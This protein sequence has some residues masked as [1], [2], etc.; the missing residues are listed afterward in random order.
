MRE[1][2]DTQATTPK[3][4]SPRRRLLKWCLWVL[5]SPVLLFLLL[6][7]LVY[8]PPVQDWAVG[9]ATE[10]LSE[11]T[12]KKVSVE[13]L[14]VTPLL[15]VELCN[16][17]ILNPERLTDHDLQLQFCGQGNR[18]HSDTVV[19]AQSCIV[20]LDMM[21][22]LSGRIAVDAFDLRGAR[23]DTQDMLDGLVLDGRLGRFRF[24]V[25]DIE[26]KA[27]Q[28]NLCHAVVDDCR[29]D[30]ALRDTI[31]VE[32]DTTTTEIPWQLY[33]KDIEVNR[34]NIAFHSLRDTMAVRAEMEALELKRGQFDLWRQVLHVED[35][36]ANLP[37]VSYDVNYVVAE[38]SEDPGMSGMSGISGESGIS[39]KSGISGESGHPATAI[40]FNHLLLTGICLDLP[41][42]DYDLNSGRLLARLDELKGRERSGL[43]LSH[44]AAEVEL[45]TS[46]VCVRGAELQTPHSQ[47]RAEVDMDWSA[48]TPHR[49]GRMDATLSAELGKEDVMLLAGQQLP[50]ALLAAYPDKILTAEAELTGN[51]D[52]VN[53]RRFRVIMPEIMDVTA[54][55]SA[56]HLLEEG[57]LAADLT[58]EAETWDMSL[59]E[60]LLGLEGIH[61]PALQFT[62]DTHV[63]D[64]NYAVQGELL[65]GGGRLSL[66]GHYNTNLDSYEADLDARRLK[67]NNFVK[68]DSVLQVTANAY[69]KGR[70]TDLLSPR[71]A[72]RAVADVQ[73]MNYGNRDVSRVHLDALTQNG[74][75]FV[76]F[77]SANEVLD[78]D[79]CVELQVAGRKIADA[80]F[81]VDMRGIDLYSLG[82]TE[83]PLSVSM[84]LHANGHT[85]LKE[86]HYLEGGVSSMQLQTA[87]STY[88]PK[89]ITTKLLMQP[90]TLF[91][92]LS[93]GDL[94]LNLNSRQGL[95]QVIGCVQDYWEELSQ[96]MRQKDFSRDRLI[97]RLPDVDLCVESGRQN[98][99]ANISAMMGYSYKEF[100]IDIHTD[101]VSGINGHGWIHA[102]NTGSIVLDTIQFDVIQNERGM[103]LDS[104]VCNGRRN[105]DISFDARLKATLSPQSASFGLVYLDDRGRKGVD[106]GAEATFHGGTTRIHLNPLR[107]ILA[108]RYFTLNDSNF[109]AIDSLGHVEA[110]LDLQADDGTGLK[111][112]SMPNEMADQDLTLSLNRFNLGELCSVLPYMPMITG[113]LQGDVHLQKM[114]KVLSVGA[115]LLVKDMAYEGSPM[116]D[117]GINA[118]YMPNE[119]GSHY[120]DGFLSQYGLEIMAFSGMYRDEGETDQ[121][122]ADVDLQRFPL[123]MANGFLGDM[124]Q[125]SGYFNGGVHVGGSSAKPSIEGRLLTESMHLL[126]PSY[127]IDLRVPDDT[128]AVVQNRLDL[129]R[130]MAYSTGQRPLQLGGYVDF[131]DFSNIR[132]DVSASARNFELV[133]APRNRKAELYG[134]VFVDLSLLARGHVSDLNVTGNLVVLGNTDLTYVLKDSPITVEDEMADLVTFV[135]FGDTIEVE[136][137]EVVPPSNLNMRIGV[138][139]DQAAQVHCLLSEDGVNYANLEGGGDLTLTYDERRGLQLFGRYT[140]LQ[141]RMNYTLMVMSLK[142]CDIASGSYVDFNGDIM[143]PRLSIAASERLNTTITENETP[144]SVAFNVGMNVTQTLNDMGLEFTL[145]APEDMNIQNELAQMTAEQRGR[146]AVTLMATGMYVVEGKATGGFNT[147]NALNSFL[148][149]QISQITGKALNS[150]DLSLGVQNTNTA[151]GSITTDYSFRFAKR[152]WGNRISLI[153]G[154]KVS[155]GS[156]AENTGQ[157]I[158]DNVSIE[159]RLD[160]SA[161]RYVTLYY[162]NNYESILE[163]QV[164][165]MGAGLVLRRKTSR[166]GELFLFRNKE[167]TVPGDDKSKRKKGG[168][169]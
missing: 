64:G 157:S 46:K 9:V 86:N 82:V 7:I 144:R 15:D 32:E 53:L 159:Y 142:D 165:E 95:G 90:D 100:D 3:R 41:S 58:W 55:G 137:D 30:I 1:Q 40:D 98:P 123:S 19:C 85:D 104:R 29:L 8:L 130:L 110:D 156:E 105:P 4:R 151:S 145:E 44:L 139:I 12:G 109:V 120:V 69:L 97:A 28:V 38:P 66:D 103:L 154:G 150:V 158:I 67:V 25:H 22:L 149:S 128:I 161:T 131:G 118:A 169:K 52:S 60:R 51:I 166:L 80:S 102:V 23:V 56:G 18:V 163:G 34:S 17:L 59:V 45:D 124:L 117:V 2:N 155:S 111:L 147:T 42:L 125:L 37:R 94:E 77:Q 83:K 14:R 57:Q 148:N 132:L 106:L 167:A 88:Y 5:F 21:H 65:Q 121:I 33:F 84:A 153:V 75:S 136:K 146:V 122:D 114:E 89:D 143:N 164:A 13:R 92:Y 39:G 140:I 101:T 81:S 54:G 36:T 168:A 133:N 72:L 31:V 78:A 73:E 68:M 70:G 79:G 126:S 113:Y 63:H 116:G 76:N 27:R 138:R 62:G 50:E 24:D 35:F 162:D 48:L 127:S 74:H 135:D 87:D 10:K 119:D 91:A 152:F 160:K 47:L 43:E 134:K 112:F 71:S 108:Y 49:R 96:Q 129:S 107:P 11:A 141:G 6:T 93:A 115:D 99:L 16:L 20:D 61:I 26:L